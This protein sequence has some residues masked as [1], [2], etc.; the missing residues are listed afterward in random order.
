[1]TSSDKPRIRLL[2]FILKSRSN[3]FVDK[4]TAIRSCYNPASHPTGANLTQ[5]L[6]NRDINIWTS[7]YVSLWLQEYSSL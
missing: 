2:L 3:K 6:P 5:L 4:V 7:G 1:M